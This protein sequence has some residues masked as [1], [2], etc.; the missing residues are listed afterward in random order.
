MASDFKDESNIKIGGV[1]CYHVVVF[2]TLYLFIEAYCDI[3][4]TVELKKKPACLTIDVP[5]VSVGNKK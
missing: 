4:K 2:L 5:I 1:D 3:C